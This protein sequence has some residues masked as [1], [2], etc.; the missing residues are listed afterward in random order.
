MGKLK[1]C[2]KVL[3]LDEITAVFQGVHVRSPFFGVVFGLDFEFIG[4]SFTFQFPVI[5][6]DNTDNDLFV[7]INCIAA[8]LLPVVH[9]L[10]FAHFDLIHHFVTVIDFLIG[11]IGLFFLKVFD[12]FVFGFFEIEIFSFH[13]LGSELIKD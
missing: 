8:L 13:G 5:L 11:L 2:R 4:D 3:F 1:L 9:F 6:T 7:L 10:F 12:F